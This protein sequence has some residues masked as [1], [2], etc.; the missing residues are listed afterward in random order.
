MRVVLDI[1]E[2]G[3]D[4]ASSLSIGRDALHRQVVGYDF[5]LRLLLV[6][7]FESPSHRR[8]SPIRFAKLRRQLVYPDAV[9]RGLPA[10]ALA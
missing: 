3:G 9:G 8:S 4:E 5:T 10:E 2:G 7:S 6:A 1:L